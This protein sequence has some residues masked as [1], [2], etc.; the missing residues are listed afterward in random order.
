MDIKK[1][2]APA[3]PTP[4]TQEGYF[5]M[6]QDLK[7]IPKIADAIA[8]GRLDPEQVPESIEEIKSMD[9]SKKLSFFNAVYPQ[10]VLEDMAALLKNGGQLSDDDKSLLGKMPVSVLMNL[11]DEIQAIITHPFYNV[12][13]DEQQKEIESS[14][15]K[16]VDIL[17]TVHTPDFINA[18]EEMHTLAFFGLQAVF[19]RIQK[20]I[21]SSIDN[22]CTEAGIN[23]EEYNH[24]MQQLKDDIDKH[25]DKYKGYDFYRDDYSI[26]ADLLTK[27]KDASS[28]DTLLPAVI[29]KRASNFTFP[30][31]YTNNAIFWKSD[32]FYNGGK[33]PIKQEKSGSKKKVSTMV[34][35]DFDELRANGKVTISGRKELSPYDNIIYD[36]VG[37]L[38]AAGNEYI[39]PRMILQLISGNRSKGA[40]KTQIDAV[41]NSL[42]KMA[43][44]Y[45][46]ID[47]TE[48]HK[49]FGYDLFIYSG[50]LLPGEF[51]QAQINGS[52]A[53]CLHLFREP[54]LRTYARQKGH[55]ASVDI[56]LLDTPNVSNTEE[57]II[58]KGYLLRQINAIKKG[59]ISNTM[60]YD[61]VYEH[62]QLS[63]PSRKQKH[64]VRTKIKDILNEWKAQKFIEKYEETQKNREYYS[65]IIYM[66]H[67]AEQPKHTNTT[68]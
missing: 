53:S 49:A 37:T 22:I 67:D 30:T 46:Q 29:S 26:I 7:Q 42:K 61:T 20:V 24:W 41:E 56:K 17:N 66:L 52:A 48:E 51:V 44:T 27:L 19:E 65:I 33:I 4:L 25:P 3:E 63:D 43:F 45:L 40:N 55:I 50:V 8:L 54:P 11:P 23:R 60:R 5:N 14:A 9:P 2:K 36:A 18:A 35:V 12:F 34:S 1:E 10:I 38:Y 57:T 16:L 32:N 13:S 31:A 58:L 68:A 59:K 62:L 64:R 15:L 6:T 28:S 39:T 47:A 21:D